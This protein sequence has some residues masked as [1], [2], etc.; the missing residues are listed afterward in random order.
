MS[1]LH[2]DQ[3]TVEKNY[4]TA[5]G[6]TAGTGLVASTVIEVGAE[7]M[8]LSDCVPADA[9]RYTIQVERNLH[10][11]GNDIRFLNHSCDPNTFVDAVAGKVVSTCRIE[12]GDELTFFYPSTEWDMSSPFRC[13]CGST[14]CVGEVTG[15][16]FLTADALKRYRINAHIEELMAERD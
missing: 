7:V 9:S 5:T 12:P 2:G 10:V 4:R 13:A 1:N 15:A 14:D 16:A 11:I 3:L 8:P 6:C